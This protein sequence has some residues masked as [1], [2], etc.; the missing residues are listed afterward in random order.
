MMPAMKSQCLISMWRQRDHD[1]HASLNP[2]TIPAGSIQGTATITIT[3]TANDGE[4]EDEK[5]RLKS[6]AGLKAED[7]DGIDV[8]LTIN[9]VDITL[10]DTADAADEE[11]EPSQ[12]A[13]QD[14]TRP[15]FSADAAIA[16]QVYTE[17]TAIDPL[18]LPEAAGD[19]TPFTYNVFS[20]GLPAG[21]TFHSAT[22][23]LSGTPAAPT[24]GP[25]S[26]I[27]TVVDSD[28]DAGV[29]LTFSITVNAAE[30][31]EV[32]PPAI[33]TLRLW[34]LLR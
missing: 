17:G 14:P 4:E 32:P 8:P 12:P 9:S 21:L 23:T 24:D 18:V 2:L 20:L 26:V 19:D 27:Y 34:R 13:P 16:D 3:P 30:E 15:S 31:T 11:D 28:G 5:I 10:K 7:E 33:P 1:Y 6:L 29:P 22:R 25:V